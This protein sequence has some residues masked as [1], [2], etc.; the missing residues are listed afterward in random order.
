MKTQ[1]SVHGHADPDGWAAQ[2]ACRRVDPELFFPVTSSGPSVIQSG[3]AK[4]V[5][6]HCPV[7]QPCLE[8]ALKTGQDFGVWG[9]VSADERR[10]IRRR[11]LG[12]RPPSR[13]RH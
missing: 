8:Y 11:E 10:L 7:R 5:C 3:E 12:H 1:I 13:S 2:G 6:S 4:Q 9:G